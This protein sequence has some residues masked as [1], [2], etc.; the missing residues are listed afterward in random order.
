MLFRSILLQDAQDALF[1]YERLAGGRDG[2]VSALT[3]RL[4]EEDVKSLVSTK[5]GE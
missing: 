5:V 4:N 3:T 2:G 1:D